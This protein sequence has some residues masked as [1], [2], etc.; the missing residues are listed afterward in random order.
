[1][2]TDTPLRLGIIGLGNQGQEHLIAANNSD[3]VQFVVG[4]DPSTKSL[5]KAQQLQP[6][7][8][9]APDTLSL[10]GYALDGLVIALPHHCYAEI[11]DDVLALGLPILK[12]K[13]LAR[14]LAESL[15]LLSQAQQSGCHVQTA[16]QRRHHPSYQALQQF[17]SA[18]GELPLEAHAHLHLGFDT[19]VKNTTWRG[20]RA[21]AGG[22]ALLDSGYHLIDLLHYLIGPFELVAASL[23]QDDMPVNEQ[24]IDDQAML[25]GRGERCWVMLESCVGKQKSEEVVIKTATNIWSANREGL[26]RNGLL[27]SSH[28]RGWE[29]AMCSQ[30]DTFAH[31]IRHGTWDSDMIWDQ[32]PA[33]RLID[34][35]YRLASRY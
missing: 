30:L 2:Q 4:I 23:W 11:W 8:A 15:Q 13:P 28:P 19:S 1:M 20:D 18:S 7:L 16:I 33:M 35:A 12:E 3:A 24:Q 32:I 14:N 26:W 31:N 17:I 22:G 27:I 10:A 9:I 29:R 34:S 6:T 25:V 21:S 5:Y